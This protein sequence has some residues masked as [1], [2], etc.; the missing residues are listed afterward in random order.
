MKLPPLRDTSSGLGD[1][2]KEA[3]DLFLVEYTF[4]VAPESIYVRHTTKKTN[5]IYDVNIVV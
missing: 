1:E 3:L 2:A 4:M 5:F